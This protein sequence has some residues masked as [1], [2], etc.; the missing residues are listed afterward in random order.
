MSRGREIIDDVRQDG[1]KVPVDRPVFPTSL[2]PRFEKVRAA[3][4]TAL[5]S[6]NPQGSIQ[7]VSVFNW[8]GCDAGID[9]HQG[10]VTDYINGIR[11]EIILRGNTEDISSTTRETNMT[12]SGTFMSPDGN[13]GAFEIGYVGDTPH[14]EAYWLQ[15]TGGLRLEQV[16]SPK[17]QT[18]DAS[19]LKSYDD[20]I[21]VPGTGTY[22]DR[23]R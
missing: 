6:K 14:Y 20:K 23:Y 1:S 18:Y 5:K 8:S 19:Q 9:D 3:V 21:I 17:N 10:K 7:E 13:K 15:S 11:L 4:E 16:V 12:I 22:V 2:W